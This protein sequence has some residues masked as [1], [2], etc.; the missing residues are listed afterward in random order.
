MVKKLIV[1]IDEALHE[2]LKIQAI[3]E[4]TTLK[5][6]VTEKLESKMEKV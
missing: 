4:K 3:R 6:L 5:K 1:E 2:K